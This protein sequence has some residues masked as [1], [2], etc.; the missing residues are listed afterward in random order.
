[1]PCSHVGPVHPQAHSS[2]SV[3]FCPQLRDPSVGPADQTPCLAER[4]KVSDPYGSP[5]RSSLACSE[6]TMTLAVRGPSLPCK[7]FLKA[8]ETNLQG[9]VRTLLPKPH[10]PIHTWPSGPLF[11][12]SS[13][14]FGKSEFI[15]FSLSPPWCPSLMLSITSSASS[16]GWA[17]GVYTGHLYRFG[18]TICPSGV[19]EKAPFHGLLE[20]SVGKKHTHTLGLINLALKKDLPRKLGKRDIFFQGISETI[21][22]LKAAPFSHSPF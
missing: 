2:S 13:E 5:S 12:C 18:P 8:E 10:L 6:P 14:L 22:L 1:M 9:R 3:S 11:S 16:G 4:Q 7:A 21:L 15:L 17:R 20:G 19:Q